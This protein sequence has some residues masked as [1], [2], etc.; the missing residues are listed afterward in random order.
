VVGVGHVRVN[1]AA[2]L[3]ADVEDVTEVKFDPTAVVRS[4][5]TITES[6][7]RSNPQGA[8]GARANMPA[9]ASASNAATPPVGGAGGGAAGPPSPATPP[10]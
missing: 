6:D 3:K 10:D 1:V 4:K 5:Q 7:T 9:P 2:R 8:A